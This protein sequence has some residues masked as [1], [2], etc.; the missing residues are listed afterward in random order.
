MIFGSIA[1]RSPPLSGESR[2][3]NPFYTLVT[4]ATIADLQRAARGEIDTDEVIRNI[5]NRIQNASLFR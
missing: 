2:L 5:Y 1:I 4:E 3:H